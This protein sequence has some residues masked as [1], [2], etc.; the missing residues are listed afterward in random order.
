MDRLK[1]LLL[2]AGLGLKKY[3]DLV[4]QNEKLFWEILENKITEY[5]ELWFQVNKEKLE[6]EYITKLEEDWYTNEEALAFYETIRWYDDY[7]QW[8]SDKC[9]ETI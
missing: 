8:A 5:F 3:K 1:I 2:T 4:K 7:K 9:M 6:I